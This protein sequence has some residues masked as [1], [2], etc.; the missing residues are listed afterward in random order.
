M[1]KK[2]TFNLSSMLNADSINTVAKTLQRKNIHYTKLRPHDKNHYSLD[3]IETLADSIEDIGLQQELVIK[4]SGNEAYSIII[5]HRRHLAIKMLVEERGLAQFAE[6]PCVISNANE[7]NIITELKLHLT[8]TTA[9][10]LSEYDK[11]TA[12]SELKRL[13][14]EAKAAGHEIKGTV[15]DIIADTMNMGATQVG[16]Y[17]AIDE[18]AADD[19][20]AEL[21]TG[22]ITV[23][24]AYETTKQKPVNR[25]NDVRKKLNALKRACDAA[26]NQELR[27]LVAEF[28]LRIDEII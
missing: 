1:P 22:N 9:R 18:K 10:E 28:A 27:E 12:I 13:I 11:M 15:R 24:Q 26:D 2:P 19:V 5:G 16:K 25:M 4:P 3:N 8:N 6:I 7:D 17:T 23:E 20:K 14:T 21:K